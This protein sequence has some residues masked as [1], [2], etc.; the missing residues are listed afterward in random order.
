MI[1]GE[2]RGLPKDIQQT[3]VTV[4]LIHI[5]ILAGY[6]LSLVARNVGSVAKVISRRFYL[7]MTALV[8]IMYVLMTGGA[9]STTR[10]AIMALIGMTARTSGRISIALRSLAVAV[11]VMILWNPPIL[12]WDTGF[13][14]SALATFGLITLAPTIK[15]I[16]RFLPE[17]LDLR[18]IATSTLSVQ[19]FALP[20]LL[21]FTGNFSLISVPANLLALPALPYAMF[22]GFVSALLNFIH[23]VVAFI[24]A[25]ITYVLVHYILFI[26][27]TAASVPYGSTVITSF[28]LW[29]VV[30]IYIP[31]FALAINEYQAA[32][33]QKEAVLER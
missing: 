28:P 5:V 6:A 30:L 4:G 17:R 29:A 33:K 26:A 1:F 7:P 15:P 19:I 18:E 24:P 10:A 12:L 22:F 32:S 13:I 31:L 14:V 16:F 9:A 3:L 25:L 21:Y 8:L 20:A 27:Q 2:R 23:P 11:A